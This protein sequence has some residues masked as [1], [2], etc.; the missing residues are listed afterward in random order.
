MIKQGLYNETIEELTE[1][2]E[3]FMENA[4]NGVHMIKLITNFSDIITDITNMNYQDTTRILVW[5]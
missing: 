1:R 5:T 4:V 2:D 3:E